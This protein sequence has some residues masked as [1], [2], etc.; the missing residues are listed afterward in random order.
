MLNAAGRRTLPLVAALV[1]L[2]GAGAARAQNRPSFTGVG[3]LAGG[4]FDSGAEAVSD[5]GAVVVGGS[6]STAGPEAFRWTAAGGI[7]GMGDLSGGAFA[8]SATGVSANGSVIVGTGVNSSDESRAFR[9]T[10]GSGM[11][12]LN[13][14]LCFLCDDYAYGNKVSSNGLVAVGGSNPDT[15][16]LEAVRWTGGGT[17]VSALGWLSGGGDFSEASAASATGSLLVG[18]SDSSTG[19][20]AF[21]WTSGGGLV[22]LPNIAGA[23]VKAGAYDVSDD[24][25]VIVGEANGSAS[26]TS[27]PRAVRWLGPSYTTALQLGE[28]PGAS[29]P[30]S[31]A[32]GVSANGAIIVG[33]ANDDESDDAAFVWD[34]AHGMRELAQ[35]LTDVFRIPPENLVTQGYGE[36]FMKVDTQAPER[37]NRR[38]AVRRITPLLSQR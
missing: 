5:D 17:S 35:V 8:S 21:R 6:E 34:A 16:S 29:F 26:N 10:S 1:L 9:W 22:A 23:M 3:D 27:L 24:G 7:V 32:L 33:L 13:T 18:T 4:A 20:R 2:A 14:L 31:R 30:T 12:A 19:Q 37:I 36:Q 25:N 38:V 11:V 15:N 28:L